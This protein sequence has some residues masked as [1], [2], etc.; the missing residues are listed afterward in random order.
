MDLSVLGI[1]FNLH[2]YYLNLFISELSTPGVSR[3]TLCVHFCCLID[4][5]LQLCHFA[6][7]NLVDMG[8]KYSLDFNSL[9]SVQ[10][11]SFVCGDFNC[12]NTAWGYPNIDKNGNAALDWFEAQDIQLLFDSKDSTYLLL[13]LPWNLDLS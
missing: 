7:K 2:P 3:G 8:L 5:Y 13:Q 10:Q 4:L 9:P 6:E 11:S 1:F 12:R